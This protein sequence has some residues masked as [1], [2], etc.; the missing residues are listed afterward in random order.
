MNSFA[1]S[2]HP[3]ALINAGHI[4]H[5]VEDVLEVGQLYQT[6]NSRGLKWACVTGIAIASATKPEATVETVLADVLAHCDQKVVRPELEREL[7]KTAGMNDIRELRS[8]FDG[9]Y[10]G[11]GIP[12]AFSSANE[13]VTKGM[14]I[15]QMARGDARAAIVAGVNMG[16]D[17]DCV[18]AVAGGISGALTG[19]S[20]IPEKLDCAA[21]L[22]DP[23]RIRIRILSAA[24]ANMPT[25]FTKPLWLPCRKRKNISRSWK[26]RRHDGYKEEK[27]DE[28]HG[29]F[30]ITRDSP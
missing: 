30:P 1:R 9:V 10:S 24:C 14:C 7:R 22:C 6:S 17:T 26:R 18:A 8:Y 23:Q 25:G 2:C 5:A 12:Y 21:G 29:R 4:P 19:A 3:I 15:F 16:R 11:R 13:V 27:T 20:S 28:N